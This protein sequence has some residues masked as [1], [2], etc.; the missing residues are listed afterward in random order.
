MSNTPFKPLIAVVGPTSSGKSDL[1]VQIALFINSQKKY[2]GVEASEV[3]SADSRQVYKGMD[4]GTGKVTRKEMRGVP[5]HMLDIASP[6]RVYTASQY[7]RD[8]RKILEKI[9]KKGGVPVLCGGTGFYIQSLLEG[10][11]IPSVKPDPSLR[12][13]LGEKTVEE[14]FLIL[15]SKDPRRSENIDSQ[16]PHRLIR[17]IEIAENLGYVP[18]IKYKPLKCAALKIGISIPQKELGERIHARLHKRIR[19]GMFEE[20]INLHKSGVSWKRL[21]GLG[22]EYRYGSFFLRRRM[23]KKEA[24]ESLEREIRKY[25]KRQMT[26]F[27][28]DKDIRW[29]QKPE[30]SLKLVQNFLT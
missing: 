20:I 7:Q 22:L 18:K 28:R 3:I 13:R 25:A 29:I 30:D 5:H 24:V 17:A 27:K 9:W 4:I 26:W 2:F 14:L 16:N 10:T 19:E 1:A 23:E 11:Q 12:K 21:E 6:K 15:K 8:A